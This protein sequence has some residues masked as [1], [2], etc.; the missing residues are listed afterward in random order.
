MGEGGEAGPMV[1]SANP[2]MVFWAVGVSNFI[3]ALSD[4]FR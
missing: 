3:D 2:I 4:L 1:M